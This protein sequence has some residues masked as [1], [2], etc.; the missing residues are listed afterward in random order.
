[1]SLPQ[2]GDGRQ[3]SEATKRGEGVSALS[4]QG[5]FIFCGL[6]VSDLVHTSGGFVGI[7]SNSKLTGK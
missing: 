4:H 5:V 2:E 1:M 7:L 3:G 6:N